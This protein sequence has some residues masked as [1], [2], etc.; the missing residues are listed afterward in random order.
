[1][2]E[3]LARWGVAG[4]AGSF[5]TAGLASVSYF[6]GAQ[7]DVERQTSRL[8]DLS[9]FGVP[10]GRTPYRARRLKRQI[11]TLQKL[12]E[13]PLPSRAI[14]LIRSGVSYLEFGVRARDTSREQDLEDAKRV[15]EAV[16][17][18][19]NTN[20]HD[21]S[22]FVGQLV[23]DLLIYDA[24]AFEYVR[25][26]KWMKKNDVLALEIV[27]GFT[28]AQRMDWDGDPDEPRWVQIVDGKIVAELLDS[29][30]EY[31]MQ[32][33]RSW[34]TFGLSPLEVA[35]ELM[36]SFL[37]LSAYQKQVASNAYPSFMLYLGNEISQEQVERFR[38]YWK[39]ELQ[40]Q[41]APGIWGG[42]SGRPEALQL[43]PVGDDGLY[44][45]YQEVLIRIFAFAFNL[46]PQD[47]GIERDVN[48][49]QGEVSAWA[50]IEEARKPVA[51]LIERKIN[52]RVIPTIAEAAGMPEIAEVEFY[53]IGLDPRDAQADSVMYQRYLESGVMTPDDV[54]TELG[55]TVFPKGLG[56]MPVW[57]LK[58]LAV[59]N[60]F[61]FVD[62]NQLSPE[63][64]EAVLP[65][66]PVL[67]KQQPENVKIVPT[68]S[69][70]SEE[71][72][73]RLADKDGSRENE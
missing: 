54:R 30:I 67:V 5:E 59:V 10:F 1:M 38:S 69:D 14:S 23:E 62:L 3:L 33:K 32:R 39:M 26:P 55:M 31:L 24:G 48:R 52:T 18:N 56:S 65:E 47:F 25:R 53:W 19:P 73:L 17:E 70:L 40:G 51:K 27:P 12:S 15:V 64:R 6:E 37:N 46:K 2:K 22:T 9:T 11:S 57:F 43:K 4:S 45:K 50:S 29:D 68:G 60:P 35:I 36:E 72:A 41:G 61:A 8:V 21:F 63:E 71:E 28:L 13:S 66:S 20:D 42:G 7:K 44:L 49:S 16:I 58:E 34:T